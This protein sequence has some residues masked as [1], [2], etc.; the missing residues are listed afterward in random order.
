MFLRNGVG[1]ILPTLIFFSFSITKKKNNN[2][3]SKNRRVHQSKQR[4][5]LEAIYKTQQLHLY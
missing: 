1:Q 4:F 3:R 2:K 5:L